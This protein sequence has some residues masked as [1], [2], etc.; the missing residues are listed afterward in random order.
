MKRTLKRP[1]RKQRSKIP[2]RRDDAPAAP[3]VARLFSDLQLL[4]SLKQ[5]I[6]ADEIEMSESEHA[7]LE[8]E[9]WKY[10]MDYLLTLEAPDF[11]HVKLRKVRE[12]E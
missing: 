9:A 6:D 10:L 4:R 3:V 11:L 1:L 5:E 2:L 7:E 12:H 8:R